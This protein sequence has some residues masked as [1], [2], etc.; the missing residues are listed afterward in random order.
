MFAH[1]SIGVSDFQKSLKL[2]DAIMPSIGYGRLFGD[3][4]DDFM[5][6]GPEES[7]FIINTPENPERGDV[8]FNNGGHICL[9]APSSEAVDLFY[10]KAIE[11]GVEDAGKPGLRPHYS[12]D[13]YAAFILDYDGN[14]IEVMARKS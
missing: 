10:D 13:Y 5:A 8:T 11:L 4:E 12:K 1:V 7:F 6:Y 3:E 9:K 2:Y 14:K